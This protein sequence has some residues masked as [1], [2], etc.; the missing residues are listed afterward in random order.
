MAFEEPRLDSEGRMN[1]VNKYSF[2]GYASPRI[3]SPVKEKSLK[4]LELSKRSLSAATTCDLR[5][6]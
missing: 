2:F 6:P 4:L 3:L 1:H 5:Y